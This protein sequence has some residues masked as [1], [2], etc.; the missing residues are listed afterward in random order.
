MSKPSERKRRKQKARVQRKEKNQQSRQSFL[1]A[2]N[3]Q[4]SLAVKRRTISQAVHQTVCEI[5]QSD[6]TGKC[7]LYAV[8]GAS[9]A[10]CVLD[11]SY[12]PQAGSLIIQ[13]GP[14]SK[15]CWGIEPQH[16]E[17]AFLSGEFHC[18]FGRATGRPGEC[19]EA[20]ELVDLSARH[21]RKSHANFQFVGEANPPEWKLPDPPDFIWTNSILP[22]WLMLIP[23]QKLTTQLLQH[24]VDKEFSWKAVNKLAADK[25]LKLRK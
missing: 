2:R 11:E 20:T 10:S 1:A 5:T 9:L 25:Y 8:I 15:D 24:I 7:M 22:E 3:Q 14:E 17:N 19:V 21:Y 13:C 23:E 16:H 18:W 12:L 6:G 4:K